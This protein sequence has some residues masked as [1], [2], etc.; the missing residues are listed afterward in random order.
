[1]TPPS[2]PPRSDL[3]SVS[4]PGRGAGAPHSSLQQRER[5]TPHIPGNHPSFVSLSY[6]L[7][8]RD[9]GTQSG[10]AWVILVPHLL[11]TPWRNF[12]LG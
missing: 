8:A 9:L 5:Q 6:P 10:R 3:G 7:G 12:T 2:P 4:G 1:M 11:G